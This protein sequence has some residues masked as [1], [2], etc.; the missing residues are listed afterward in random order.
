MVLK[1]V[2]QSFV[3]RFIEKPNTMATAARMIA[4]MRTLEFNALVEHVRHPCVLNELRAVLE[5][6]GIECT[7]VEGLTPGIEIRVLL[8]AF[9]AGLHP[10]EWFMMGP[11]AGGPSTY[12]INTL[13][14]RACIVT[15]LFERLPEVA[16]RAHTEVDLF[17][18]TLLDY[19][20]LLYTWKHKTADAQPQ[21]DLPHRAYNTLRV[22]LIA[23]ET[24]DGRSN[25]DALR[26]Q[27]DRL[28]THLASMP[29]AEPLLR[30]FDNMYSRY[31]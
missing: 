23:L 30:S 6:Y 7:A 24:T 2:P 22:M 14:N 11:T 29:N 12:E 27:I 20:R 18:H 3:L 1:Y 28:R 8:G 17:V 21:M 5:A 26:Q 25:M 9:V 15:G 4:H 31:A 13:T 16:V 10:V 19:Q